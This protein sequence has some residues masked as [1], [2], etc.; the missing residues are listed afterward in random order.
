MGVAA[1][2]ASVGRETLVELTA[3]L[4]I[5]YI[6]LRRLVDPTCRPA[7]ESGEAAWRRGLVEGVDGIGGGES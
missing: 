1:Q 3:L 4:I 7:L 5:Y 2:L 6:L